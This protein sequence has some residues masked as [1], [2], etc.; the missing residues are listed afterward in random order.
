LSAEGIEK[1]RKR[2]ED[3]LA[4]ENLRFLVARVDEKIA[5]VCLATLQEDKNQLKAIYVLPEFQGRGIGNKLWNEVL[6]FIDPTK[7]T[8]VEVV[9]HNKNAIE[10][11]KRLGF[12]DTGRRWTDE[13]FKMKSGATF[14]E[15]ELM[16]K[17]KS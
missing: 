8:T 13:K 5:G 17:G 2:I 4:L 6:R 12:E 7:K 15:M 9:I 1:S 14:P 3:G 10:F 11:Y 16:I